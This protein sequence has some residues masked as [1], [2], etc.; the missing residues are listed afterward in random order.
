MKLLWS[1]RSNLA[2]RNPTGREDAG[3]QTVSG[4]QEAQD[5]ADT[6]RK[7]GE[8]H[9]LSYEAVGGINPKDGPVAL[10]VGGW[11]RSVRVGARMSSEVVPRNRTD[12]LMW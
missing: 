7:F 2:L 11:N 4:K 10:C 5:W 12:G 6:V 3:G 8:R 9:E 1:D